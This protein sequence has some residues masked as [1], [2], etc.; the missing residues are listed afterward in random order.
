MDND[1][2][3]Q[4]AGERFGLQ[5]LDVRRGLENGSLDGLKLASAIGS[6]WP[7]RPNL[8]SMAPENSE[9]QYTAMGAVQPEATFGV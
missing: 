9:P 1:F 5:P 8:N 4:M 2:P 6:L 7:S 3:M